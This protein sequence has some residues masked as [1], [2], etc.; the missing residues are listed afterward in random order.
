MLYNIRNS[1]Q[2]E[3]W[4]KI[5]R[6]V[7]EVLAHPERQVPHEELYTYLTLPPPKSS[8]ISSRVRSKILSPPRRAEQ[9]IM[10]AANDI[11]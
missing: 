2:T 5:L 9:S 4:P 1:Y 10:Y 3:Y 11:I 8:C 6:M 7:R